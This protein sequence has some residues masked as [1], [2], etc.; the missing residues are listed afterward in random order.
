MWDEAA[1]ISV[2]RRFAGSG[3]TQQLLLNHGGHGGH[4]GM[5]FVS[6]VV[7]MQGTVPFESL[8]L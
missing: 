6:S 3:S 7:K 4:G 1:E 8:S 2:A 5:D